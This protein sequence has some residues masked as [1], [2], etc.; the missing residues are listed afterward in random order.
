MTYEEIAALAPRALA[1]VPTGCTEQQGPHLTVDFDTWFAG[2]VTAAAADALDAEGLPV[3]VTP[4]LPFGPTPE[5]RNFGAGFIDIPLDLYESFVAAI[6]A[7]LADQGFRRVV[8]WRGCGQHDLRGLVGQFADIEVVVPDSPFH[9]IWCRVADASV[10]G[11]HADSFT[12]SISL[13]RRSHSVRA[14]RIPSGASA[15]PD[16]EDPA[17]DF[18]RYS[19]TGVIGSAAHASAELGDELWRACVDNVAGILRVIARQ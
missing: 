7:S 17:L 5:H 9:D 6:V 8:L 2:A 11:G 14:D 15:E 1:V 19:D 4:A 12:T 18:T 13:A 3:V 10:P 16:W